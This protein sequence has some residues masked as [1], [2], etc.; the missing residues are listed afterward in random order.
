MA[1][2]KV[3]DKVKVVAFVPSNH[4]LGMNGTD[5][6]TDL[7]RNSWTNEMDSYV[8]NGE[9]YTIKKIIHSGVYFVEKPR[10][11]FPALAL[12][13]ANKKRKIV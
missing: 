9:I 6:E 4:F 2:F 11:G 3:G 1:N 8:N 12:K 10:Y 13:L 5:L 7:W